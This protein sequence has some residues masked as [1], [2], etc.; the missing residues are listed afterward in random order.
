MTITFSLDS[1]P[2]DHLQVISKALLNCRRCIV[3]TGAGIS[4]GG[5]IPVSI[6]IMHLC[7]EIYT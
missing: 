6:K 3:I 1:D 4:V 2:D 5:G 7:L